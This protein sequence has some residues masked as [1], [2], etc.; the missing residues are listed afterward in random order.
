[1]LINLW[2]AQVIEIP[3]VN[4]II[5][6]NRGIMNGLKT[7]IPE[8]GHFIPNSIIWV[9]LRWKNLQK[10]EMKKKISDTINKIIPNFILKNTLNEWNPWN[11]LSREISRHHWYI[12]NKIIIIDKKYIIL[13]FLLNILMVLNNNNIV[14]NDR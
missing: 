1:L 7:L 11:V 6:F 14:D 4:K 12:I 9:N 10:K 8:G 2:C 13:F 5:V 3:E